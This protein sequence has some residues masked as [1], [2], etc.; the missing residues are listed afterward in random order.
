MK[1]SLSIA[2]LL[3]ALLATAA[4]ADLSGAVADLS[5]SALPPVLT[6]S[7]AD[8][9]EPPTEKSVSGSK[10]G[11]PVCGTCHEGTKQCCGL[12]VATGAYGCYNQ[13][14]T[15]AQQQKTGPKNQA[16]L[17]GLRGGGGSNATRAADNS[18]VHTVNLTTVLDKVTLS[19]L[20]LP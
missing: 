7:A 14:C 20:A 5:N 11:P 1:A 2:A 10:T 9:V 3:G 18:T 8:K 6:S 17:Q 13:T 4:P 19:P 16:L 12:L 15:V